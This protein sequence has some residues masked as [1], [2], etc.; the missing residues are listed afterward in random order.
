[1]GIGTSLW[2]LELTRGVRRIGREMA[3]FA[4]CKVSAGGPA[5]VAATVHQLTLSWPQTVYAED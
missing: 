5:V 1:V 3:S 2:T 4:F